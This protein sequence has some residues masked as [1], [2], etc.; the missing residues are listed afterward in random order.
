MYVSECECGDGEG[1]ILEREEDD[2]R[3]DDVDETVV[4]LVSGSG[5]AASESSEMSESLEFGS[6]CWR[7]EK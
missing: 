6:S 4:C 1:L 5:G 7:G 2:G 3:E